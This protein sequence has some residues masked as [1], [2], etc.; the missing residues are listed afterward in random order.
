[1]FPTRNFLNCLKFNFLTCFFIQFCF[2]QKLPV[3]LQLSCSFKFLPYEEYAEYQRYPVSHFPQEIFSLKSGNISF[4]YFFSNLSSRDIIG[5]I[6][7]IVRLIWVL[8]SGIACEMFFFTYHIQK[9][10]V[11]FNFSWSREK[12]IVGGQ[13]SLHFIALFM[14]NDVEKPRINWIRPNWWQNVFNFKN[15]IQLYLMI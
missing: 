11:S 3:E 4:A 6:A 12:F 5:W 2:S 15:E 13:L 8:I 1:M 14:I 10:D 9:K 7:A